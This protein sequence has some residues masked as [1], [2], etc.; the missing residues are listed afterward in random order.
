MENLTTEQLKATAYDLILQNAQIQ[1][2]LQA[3]QAELTKRAQT[4][5]EEVKEA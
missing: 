3:I 5:M 1:Q 4:P 2:S